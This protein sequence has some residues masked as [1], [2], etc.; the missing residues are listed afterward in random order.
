MSNKKAGAESQSESRLTTFSHYL[1][2]G[3]ST[4]R[5]EGMGYSTRR[6]SQLAYG[7]LSKFFNL[8][9]NNRSSHFEDRLL[10]VDDIQDPPPDQPTLLQN[11]GGSTT[12]SANQVA[13]QVV[14]KDEL[15]TRLVREW[16]DTHDEIMQAR[17]S[18]TS[19]GQDLFSERKVLFVSPIRVM[20]GGAN[21]ILLIASSL[22]RMG[23]DVQIL[24]LNVHRQ[25][26]QQ[27]YRNSPVPVIFSEVKHIP[28]VAADFDAIIAT[29]N[30]TVA[31]ISKAQQLHPKLKVGY[32]I[33]DYEPYFYAQGSHE[34]QRARASYTQIPGMLRMVTTSWIAG[35]IE[36]HDHVESQVIGACLDVDLFH[37]RLRS[38]PSWPE[39][40]LRIT[41]MIRPSTPR[42]NPGLTM[43]I[44]KQISEQY[45]SK[46]EIRLFG[47]DPS[48]PGFSS[49]P[50][51]FE[52]KLAGSLRPTQVAKLFSEA[53]I[54]VDFSEFQALGL[55]ALEAMASGLAV[56]VPGNGGTI[57]Y[58]R[59]G[60]NCLV[61]DTTS[62]EA[63]LAALGRLV[64]DDILRQNLVT[65]GV[66]TT[67]YRMFP[68]L[69]A[70]KLMK[71]L[72]PREE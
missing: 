10:Q 6:I 31:W 3:W 50:V 32:F 71:T 37:P 18:I 14:P 67:T 60:E 39:R 51:D 20:G 59:H 33:Q 46:V 34:Y 44:L 57:E 49:L 56:I 42:R 68:E 69:P 8:L 4:L 53:D 43:A 5:K 9:P 36:L 2:H 24:N 48:D 29:S 54:F 15:H 16:H 19:Q 27:H 22:R 25:W 45:R 40:L 26:F 52:W 38:E 63:C 55:T 21:L 58:A 1:R 64:E 35:Q 47:C 30:P 13:G 41:A 28:Q 11:P 65:N 61:A 72:F 23:V 62:Q 17:S 12:Q 66:A 70:L 7:Q